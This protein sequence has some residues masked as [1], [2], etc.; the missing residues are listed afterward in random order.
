ME[1]LEGELD[2]SNEPSIELEPSQSP[3]V[4]SHSTSRRSSFKSEMVMSEM[5]LPPLKTPL[6]RRDD[7]ASVVLPPLVS[8]QHSHPHPPPRVLHAS[9]SVSQAGPTRERAAKNHELPPIA[10]LPPIPPPDYVASMPTYRNN[11]IENHP[12][13]GRRRTSSA[14]S[15]KGSRAGYG[16]KVV[17]CNFC[18]GESA[19]PFIDTVVL[20]LGRV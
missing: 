18:R 14:A 13:Q 8:S 2:D 19:H 5:T 9:I 16:S 10:T 15:T 11:L 4:S 6:E 12:P 17:A 1:N 20:N 7:S 3:E